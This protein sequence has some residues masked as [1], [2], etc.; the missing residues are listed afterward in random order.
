MRR[1]IIHVFLFL[2]KRLKQLFPLLIFILS[3]VFIAQDQMTTSVRKFKTRKSAHVIQRHN[4]LKPFPQVASSNTTAYTLRQTTGTTLADFSNYSIN[5]ERNAARTRSVCQKYHSL[6]QQIQL[7][8]RFNRN[9][10]LLFC[11]IYKVGTTFWRRVFMIDREKKYSKLVNPYELPFDKEYPAAKFIWKRNVTTTQYKVMFTRDPYN[12]LFSFFV[13]KMVAPNPYFWK[14]V[15]IKVAVLTRGIRREKLKTVCGHDITFPEFIK[16]VIHTLETRTN[17]DPHWIEM[18]RNCY[19][20]EM[21]YDFVGKMEDFQEDSTQILNK[22]GL[23]KMASFLEKNGKNAA[24][25]DAM[26][27]TLSQPFSFRAKYRTCMSFKDAVLRA[28]QKLQIRGLIGNDTL[29]VSLINE[30]ITKLSDI[31]LR[32]K[33]SRQSSTSLQ[34]K[35]IKN[36]MFKY[37]WGGVP[38]SDLLKLQKLYAK[39]FELFDYEKGPS[40]LFQSQ[41][42]S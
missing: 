15:G 9:N 20:C 40:I 27:D 13:D 12:R 29:D 34:R 3:F 16:Y 31:I 11:P 6:Q 19:P 30:K 36:D 42:D 14:T 1:E 25:E 41:I 7:T 32:A 26:K 28:W 38:F 18:E 8:T 33:E 21:K 5:G 23:T 39:D 35:T 37:F 22:L 10:T 2:L 4:S 17:I 24:V